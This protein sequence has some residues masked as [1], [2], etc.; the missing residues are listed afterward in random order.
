MIW[1]LH[2]LLN[3]DFESDCYSGLLVRG[4]INLWSDR[5]YKL[6]QYCNPLISNT[7]LLASIVKTSSSLLVLRRTA[8]TD[9]TRTGVKLLGD[10]MKA[11]SCLFSR[12]QTKGIIT[13]ESRY[14]GQTIFISLRATTCFFDY[15]AYRARLF[16]H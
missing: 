11:K 13:L 8:L 3:G 2:L 7:H 14:V 1:S 4:S 9:A 15:Y 5:T 10:L 12:S 6:Y 16:Y